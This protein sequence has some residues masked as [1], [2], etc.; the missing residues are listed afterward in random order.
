MAI[1]L[2]IVTVSYNTRDLL[3]DCLAAAQAGLAH[4]GLAG[5]IWVVDNASADGSAEMVRRRFPD[6][7]LLAHDENVGF[8]A[9]N[10]LALREMDPGSEAGPR[11]VLFLNPDTRV[12][13]DALGEMVRFLDATP[14]AGAAGAAL[15]HGDGGFQHSAFAFPG[16]VQIFLDFF[17]LHHRLLD[18]R[19]NGRYPRRRY[20]AGRPFPVD[21]PLGAALMVRGETL[22]QV[23]GFDERF[24]MYC[25]E[26][27]LCRRIWAA[28][29]RI[30]TL[31]GARIVH[32]VGQSTGQ[33][34]DRMF[35]AL[36]RSRFLMFH[37]HEG[38]LFRWAA[39]RLVRLGL[40]AEARRA[41]AAHARG[42]LSSDE[43]AGRLAAYRE[44]AAL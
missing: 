29:W 8:A 41:R 37:K 17:P 22:A 33:F 15:V 7:R 31:P 39:R 11:H 44:V 34:R 13:G 27:D 23:G 19:L 43:L 35:V 32:L 10:N 14:G 12:L 3:A 42:E 40:G 30:Y 25:E 21:H 5:E 28:G 26:I 36:W 18:S 6:V 1:D 4:S 24:F 9:G 16:L 2:A 38:A 20:E